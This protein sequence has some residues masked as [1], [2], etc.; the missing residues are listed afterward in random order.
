MNLNKAF[1]IGRLTRES[2]TRNTPSGQ[3]VCNFGLATNRVW[4]NRETNQKEEKTE[5]HNIVLW[6]RLAEI[7]S[8]YLTK[9]S[10]VLIEGRIQTNSW[11]DSTGNKKYRTEIVAEN[12]QLGPRNAPQSD[13]NSQ[14]QAPK[15]SVQEDIPIIEEGKEEEVQPA[16]SEAEKKSAEN[17][18]SE[19]KEEEIDVKNIPF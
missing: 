1:L 4:N 7:A 18:L 3:M 5:F 10:L 12:I 19:D 8:Q 17:K 9:G 16:E 2:E 15:K 6:G 11:Q 13:F 14:K